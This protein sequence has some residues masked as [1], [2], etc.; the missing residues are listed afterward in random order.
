MNIL[1][2]AKDSHLGGLVKHT[3]LLAKG[4]KKYEN[5]NVVIGINPGKGAEMLKKDLKV[6]SIPFGSKNP[7]AIRK[8]YKA[9]K[10]VINNNSIDI[11]HAQNRIPALY[12]YVY[13]FFHR[14]V[15]FIWAN[16]QVP[17]PISLLFRLTT[18][19]GYCAVAE[20][21]VG[22]RLL[23]DGLHIPEKEIR[24]VNLGIELE[25]FNKTSEE[26]QA[27][28]KGQLGIPSGTKVLLLYGRLA[29]SKGHMFLLDALGMIKNKNFKLILPGEDCSF[30]YEVIEKAKIIGLLDNLIFPGFVEGRDYLSIS[31]LVLLPSKNEG[32]PQA[33]VEAYSI[34]VPVIRSKTGGFE[35]TKDMCWGVDYGDVKALAKLLADF[36]EDESAFVEKATLAKQLV[37]RL[38]IKNMTYEYQRIYKEAIGK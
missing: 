4:L 24:I 16:H 10:Y 3:E 38:S 36:F 26:D 17:I 27:K 29:A 7:L 12:A 33:C 23:V 1:F 6:I 14:N 19:Y 30:K 28:L 37:Q 31:D 11:I 22:K 9:I 21:I 34:G 8:T 15:K 32:F 25:N 18:K 2:L 5:D 20:S 13:C 35:D